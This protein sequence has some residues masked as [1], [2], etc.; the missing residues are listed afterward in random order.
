[1]RENLSR[2]PDLTCPTYAKGWPVHWNF[3][4]AF[5]DLDLTDDLKMTCA[6]DVFLLVLA[7]LD[8][9]GCRLLSAGNI[10]GRL[11]EHENCPLLYGP[12]TWLFEQVLGNPVIERRIEPSSAPPS[13]KEAVG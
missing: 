5:F 11:R 1:M 8:F 10:Y 7:V 12:Q 9:Q 2:V 3:G 4:K 6:L 13:Y